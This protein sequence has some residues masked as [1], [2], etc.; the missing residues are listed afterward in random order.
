M[1]NGR[2]EGCGDRKMIQARKLNEELGFLSGNILK[3]EVQIVVTKE[4]W[5]V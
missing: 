3:I 1:T 2:G 4:V 5:V